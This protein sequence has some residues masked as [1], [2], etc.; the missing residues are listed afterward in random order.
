MQQVEHVIVNPER[1]I[2]QLQKYT[3]EGPRE[4]EHFFITFEEACLDGG[5]IGNTRVRRLKTCLREAPLAFLEDILAR[6]NNE[7]TYAEAKRQ[8]IIKFSKRQNATTHVRAMANR[9]FAPGSDTFDSY[10][11]DKMRL[12][13][14][15]IPDC[16][17]RR[18]VELIIEGLPEHVRPLATLGRYATAEALYE[19]MR[20][21]QMVDDTVLA[22]TA[23]VQR[24]VQRLDSCFP[25]AEPAAA[26]VPPAEVN[27]FQ[28]N[29]RRNRGNARGNDQNRRNLA[30]RIPA[31][32]APRGFGGPPR[33]RGQRGRPRNQPQQSHNFS[34]QNAWN[35]APRRNFRGNFDYQPRPHFPNQNWS[36]SSF[37][38]GPPPYQG[39]PAY[40]PYPPQQQT[41][42]LQFT[43]P[44]SPMFQKPC[45]ACHDASHDVRSCTNLLQHLMTAKNAHAGQPR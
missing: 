33:G 32:Q 39:P 36:N 19:G 7:L 41:P 38:Y 34:G 43:N 40:T 14:R 42:P 44:S 5:I 24:L 16:P 29:P 3:G 11:D 17:D 30:P 23:Q 26:P 1:Y 35:R 37:D 45:V 15:A 27:V 18:R 13:D 6:N 4:I 9:V 10:Y 28:A 22:L 25:A 8:L 12:I 31:P 2:E 20:N 21:V